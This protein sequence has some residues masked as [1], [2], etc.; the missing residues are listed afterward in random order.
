[1]FNTSLINTVFKFKS[2][3]DVLYSEGDAFTS[4]NQGFKFWSTKIS[5]PNNSKH[6]GFHSI[7]GFLVCKKKKVNYKKTK[8]KLEIYKFL[9]DKSKANA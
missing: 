2:V 7:T 3:C 1:M 6:C 4:I 8:K 5:Y 9:L